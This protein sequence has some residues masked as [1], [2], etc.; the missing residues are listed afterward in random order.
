MAEETIGPTVAVLGPGAVGGSLAVRLAE[1][2]VN[3]VCVARADTAEAIRS[4]GLTLRTAQQATTARLPAVEQ[5]DE[6]VDVLLVTVKA[7]ALAEALR[8]VSSGGGLVVP[9]LNGIEH[10][11]TIR[12]KLPGR[13]IAGSVG[14][15]EAYREDPLT[16]VQATPGMGMTLAAEGRDLA[17]LLRRGGA[18]VQVDGSD[19]EV[20]W[21]KLVRQAPVAAATSATQRPVGE[22][23]SNPGW[24]A[25]LEAGIDESC[26]V[27]AAE[28]VQLLPASQWEIIDTMPA[29]LTTS[30][31]RD[32][33]EGRPSELDAIT[34]A[35]VRAGRRLGVATPALEALLAE[36]EEMC[37]ARSH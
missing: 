9:L 28:G 19:R 3:V 12:G 29:N 6:P 23:R 37:R 36:A 13:V 30:T 4:K 8:R 18:Q 27:A 22:L 11:E 34:G 32:V 31:A 21:E 26:A 20:L 24:L 16:I 7:P 5:L 33:A 17:E 14:R 2:G 10:L 15:L 25:R 35:V 1:S